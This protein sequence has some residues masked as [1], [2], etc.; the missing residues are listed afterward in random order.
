MVAEAKS[1]EASLRAFARECGLNRTQNLGHPSNLNADDFFMLSP[2]SANIQVNEAVALNYSAVWAAT[3]LL[4]SIAGLLPLQVWA[5]NGKSGHLKPTREHDLFWPLSVQP[6]RAMT[7]YDVKSLMTRGQV[8]AGNGYAEIVRDGNNKPVEIV[9]FLPRQVEPE[10]LRQDDPL[11]GFK[12]G[13][14]VY[15]IT[16]EDS[17]REIRSRQSDESKNTMTLHSKDVL[18]F[19]SKLTHQGITGMGVI[20][21]A[22]DSIGMG[23]QAER[24][25]AEYFGSKGMPRLIVNVLGKMT[26]EAQ[27]EFRRQWKELYG[28][29]SNPEDMAILPDGEAKITILDLNPNDADL[30]NNRRFSVEEIARWYGIQTHL[31]QLMMNGGSINLEQFGVEFVNYSLMPWLHRQQEEY[32]AKLLTRDELARGLVI[33]YDVDN[34]QKGDLASRVSAYAKMMQFGFTL[35]EVLEKEGLPPVGDNGDV[36]FFPA[37]M[38]TMQSVIDGKNLHKKKEGGND[39]ANNTDQVTPEEPVQENV[40]KVATLPP[41]ATPQSGNVATSEVTE[42]WQKSIQ[43]RFDYKATQAIDKLRSRNEPFSRVEEFYDKHTRQHQEAVSEIPDCDLM[44][45]YSATIAELRKDWNHG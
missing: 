7:P 22:R 26:G 44:I 31:L 36:R 8:N 15:K 14:L 20:S 9:P 21:H 3:S 42:A 37:N 23:I 10:V 28:N 18:D 40:A 27:K 24:F 19:R 43:S 30:L 32:N 13:D 25:G 35:N 2:G 4:C 39:D 38:T 1:S 16:F 45:D 5:P 17:D 34:L 6:N 33:R 12:R 41:E 29:A 11:E